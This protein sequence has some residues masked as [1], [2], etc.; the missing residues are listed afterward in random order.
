MNVV[1]SKEI[2]RLVLMLTFIERLLEKQDVCLS[3][4]CFMDEDQKLF[5]LSA[6]GGA[7]AKQ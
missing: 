1:Q 5:P 4:R 3:N 7:V 2:R 6:A